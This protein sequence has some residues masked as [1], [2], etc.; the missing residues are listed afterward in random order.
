MRALFHFAA[1]V[2]L[3]VAAA[4]ASDADAIAISAAIQARHMP[5]PTLFDPIYAHLEKIGKPLHAHLAEPID[6]WLPLD[7]NSPHYSYYSQNPQWHLYGKPGYPSHAALIA[8]RI[9]STTE[10]AS[11]HGTP[12]PRS[13]GRLRSLVRGTDVVHV[14]GYRDPVGAIAARVARST[15]QCGV[16]SQ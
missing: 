9:V 15:Q 7:P 6:A 8:A 16:K 4:N 12:I 14:I 2:L 5:F 3:F 11:F 10:T 13:V 1:A